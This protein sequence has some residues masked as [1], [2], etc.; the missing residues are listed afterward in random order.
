M[1]QEQSQKYVLLIKM[2]CLA[3]LKANCFFFMHFKYKMR[4]H[5]LQMTG[6]DRKS[7]GCGNLPEHVVSLINL[8][9]WMPS[10]QLWKTLA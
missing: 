7:V 2:G 5:V 9:K 6:T 3:G 8:I 4:F 10:L 1:E